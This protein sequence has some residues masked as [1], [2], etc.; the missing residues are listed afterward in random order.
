MV[1]LHT[2]YLFVAGDSGAM[3]FEKLWEWKILP[4]V[5]MPFGLRLD[6][7]SYVMCLLVTFVG[8]LIHVYSLGYMKLK[9]YSRYFSYLNLFVA[10][11]LLLVLSDQLLFMFIGWEGVGLSSFLLIGFYH[12]SHKNMNAAKKAFIVNRI[13]DLGLLLAMILLLAIYFLESGQFSLSVLT[14]ETKAFLYKLLAL[15]ILH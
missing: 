3:Y 10:M 14:L 4:D 9:E 13:G 2:R 6:A 12:Q 11:M 7:I 8:F 5:T 1:L 15:E